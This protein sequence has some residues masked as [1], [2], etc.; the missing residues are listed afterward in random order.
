MIWEEMCTAVEICKSKV[1]MSY[2]GK[3]KMSYPKTE[4]IADE[5]DANND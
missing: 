1:V 4:G 3:V 2:S 5:Q